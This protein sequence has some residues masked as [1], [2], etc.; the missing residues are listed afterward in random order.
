[1][2]PSLTRAIFRL[3]RESSIDHVRPRKTMLCDEDGYVDAAPNS[4][5]DLGSEP[6]QYSKTIQ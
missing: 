6:I 2:L 4:D 3:S 1:L 5:L